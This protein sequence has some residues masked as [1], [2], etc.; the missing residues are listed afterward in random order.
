MSLQ[1]SGERWVQAQGHTWEPQRLWWGGR[2]CFVCKISCDS[3][4]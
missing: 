2:T 1:E 4:L 3:R